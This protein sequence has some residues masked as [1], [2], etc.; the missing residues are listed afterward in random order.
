MGTDD[1]VNID[2]GSRLEANY[3]A[4][5]ITG[6]P[7]ADISAAVVIK[8]P[9]QGNAGIGE[10]T[11]PYVRETVVIDGLEAVL[12]LLNRHCPA[13][14]NRRPMH[15]LAELGTESLRNPDKN[16]QQDRAI[17]EGGD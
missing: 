11:G 10:I 12:D 9:D 6:L 3:D 7:P 2:Y 17:T 4:A 5:L 14:V 15:E 1:V 8:L 16:T 13:P